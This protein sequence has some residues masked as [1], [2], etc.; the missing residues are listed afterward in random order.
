MINMCEAWNNDLASY[1]AEEVEDFQDRGKI[2]PMKYNYKKPRFVTRQ[3]G[4]WEIR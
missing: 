3:G 4:I 2:P 1:T